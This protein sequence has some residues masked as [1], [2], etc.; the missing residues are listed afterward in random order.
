MKM[1]KRPSHVSKNE[2]ATESGAT[3]P[4]EHWPTSYGFEHFYGFLAGETSQYE[5]R[6][7][8]DT[9]PIEPPRDPKYHLTEDIAQ[10]LTATPRVML[11]LKSCAAYSPP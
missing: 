6:L 3:G 5:P 8:N 10:Q 11:A 9:T 1:K 4:F 2:T 7:V